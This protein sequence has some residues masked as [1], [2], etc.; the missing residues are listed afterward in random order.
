MLSGNSGKQPTRDGAQN[1]R[2]LNIA[3]VTKSSLIRCYYPTMMMCS[4]PVWR[5]ILPPRENP[6]LLLAHSTR[7][8]VLTWTTRTV[9][10]KPLGKYQSN[11]GVIP[12]P[13]GE[14]IALCDSLRLMLG[15]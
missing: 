14:S 4:R 13:V 6:G 5:A 11:V 1:F 9:N 2:K 15:Y 12:H 3:V 8:Q 7:H 10:G